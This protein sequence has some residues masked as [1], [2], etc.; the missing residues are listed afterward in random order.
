M[1]GSRSTA[2]FNRSNSVLAIALPSV[3]EIYAN[4][5]PNNGAKKIGAQNPRVPHGSAARCGPHDHRY[6]EAIWASMQVAGTFS[7]NASRLT[8]ISMKVGNCCCPPTRTF[9]LAVLSRRSTSNE[10]SIFTSFGDCGGPSR[11]IEL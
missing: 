10:G 3:F 11:F 8:N 5:A 6:R 4:V 1:A 7:L 2:P 9:G